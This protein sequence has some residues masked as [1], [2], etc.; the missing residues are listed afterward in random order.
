M[1]IELE[2]TFLL[3]SLP[4]G[5]SKCEKR[6]ITDVYYPKGAVHPVLR[7][8][9]DGD[10]HELTKKEPVVEG[11]ASHQLE[12]TITL[13][14]A[15]FLALSRLPGKELHKIRY[16]Y[17]HEGKTAQIDVFQG[18]MKGLALVDFEFRTLQEK[19]AF[20]MPSFCLAEVTQEEFL[21][22]GMLCGKKYADIA[23]KLAV[24]GYRKAL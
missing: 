21:A 2:R 13:T 6:E 17:P 5:L 14:K 24:F 18:A 7:L 19:M 12:Q 16:H 1:E 9:K 10:R 15:E 20:R 22:G 23:A 4:P 11:D 8:R 3:K